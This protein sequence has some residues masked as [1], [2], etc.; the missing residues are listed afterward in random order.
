[1]PEITVTLGESSF[2]RQMDEFTTDP[3]DLLE[4]LGQDAVDVSQEA[5][6]DQGIFDK[7]NTWLPR[8][9][10][11]LAGIFSDV[12]ENRIPPERRLEPR[13]ALRDTGGLINSIS[14]QVLG[15]KVRVGTSKDYAKV[16]QEG[17]TTF[18]LKSNPDFDSGINKFISRFASRMTAKQIEKVN[19]LKD[20][21]LLRTTHRKRTFLDYNINRAEEVFADVVEK[22]FD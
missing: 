18:Q 8:P 10:P 14:Y 13:P 6:L 3:R 20:I 9:V 7:H 19:G 17:G 15:D 5:F 22:V 2:V 11:N 12:N 1:M 4:A 16:L 21:G